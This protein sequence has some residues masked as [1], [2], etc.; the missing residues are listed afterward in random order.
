[1]KKV[2]LCHERAWCTLLSGTWAVRKFRPRND[3]SISPPTD[4]LNDFAAVESIRR[5]ARDGSAGALYRPGRNRV[6]I[7]RQRILGGID[8]V[9]CSGSGHGYPSDPYCISRATKIKLTYCRMNLE[10]RYGRNVGSRPQPM[11]DRYYYTFLSLVQIFF[12][13]TC[14]TWLEQTIQA[15]TMIR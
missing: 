1:M 6:I 10:I 15:Y 4:P 13:L 12:S 11:L 2:P 9:G 7:A 5:D 8:L 14:C 3:E